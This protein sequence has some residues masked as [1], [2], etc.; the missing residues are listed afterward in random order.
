MRLQI[1]FLI[2]V[3]RLIDNLNQKRQ[4]QKKKN[5]RSRTNM[6]KENKKNTY[7]QWKNVT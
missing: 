2:S 4:T 3:Y 5:K 6:N 1:I 7:K